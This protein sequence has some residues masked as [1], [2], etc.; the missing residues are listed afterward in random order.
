MVLRGINRSGLEYSSPEGAGSLLNAG[1]TESEVHEMVVNWGANVIRL[2]FNQ[3]WALARDG[4]N[5]E[6]YLS[7]IDQVVSWAAERGAYTIIDLQWLDST[8]RRGH[9][10]TGGVNYVPPLPNELTAPMWRQ[11]ARRYRDEPAVLYDIFSEPHDPLPGDDVPLLD[12]RADE[13]IEVSDL[14]VV[15]PA[16]WHRWARLLVDVIRT[17][18]PDALLFVPGLDW[19]YDLSAFPITDRGGLVYSTH[20]YRNKGD[21]WELAFGNLAVT[22]P[23]F[24]G[25][26]G[27][28]DDDVDWGR[29]LA[30]YL[31]DLGLG[32]AAWSWSDYPHLVKRPLAPPFE[33]TEFGLLVKEQL[34]DNPLV[35]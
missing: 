4:Y 17:E 35:V 12:V 29:S 26:W 15:T 28:R 14:T 34:R 2:P 18:N 5:S 1:I 32:W 30:A 13:S 16:L 22:E 9:T 11:L 27:G 7:A 24:V 20:V 25:E 3:Q 19:A 6:P 21:A 10:A 31:A 23:V 33:P 8:T